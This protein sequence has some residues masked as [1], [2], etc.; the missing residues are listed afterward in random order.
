MRRVAYAMV[1]LGAVLG[2]SPSAGA[3]SEGHEEEGIRLSGHVGVGLGGEQ[4]DHA[5][6]FPLTVTVDADPSIYLGGRIDSVV[7]DW[8]AVGGELQVQFWRN[9]LI[10]DYNSRFDF[11]AFAKLRQVYDVGDRDLEAYLIVP[12]G[13][14]LSTVKQGQVNPGPGFNVGALLGAWLFLTEH[15]AL[16][17]EVGWIYHHTYH[18]FDMV[19][20]DA[21]VEFAEHQ[22]VILVGGAFR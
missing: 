13:F 22:A 19:G 7:H 16:S 6:A 14:T 8:I 15:Y 11:D 20:G 9:E 4:S 21:T 2:A 1:L 10:S 5:S 3:Q 17:L 18:N 12:A